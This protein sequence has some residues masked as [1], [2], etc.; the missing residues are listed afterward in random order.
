[1]S[2]IFYLKK[3]MHASSCRVQ[4]VAKDGIATDNVKGPGG[5]GNILWPP[6]GM[7]HTV[8]WPIVCLAL[9]PKC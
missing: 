5:S 9:Q 1:M 6:I 4:G 8:P 7:G 2:E 3:G